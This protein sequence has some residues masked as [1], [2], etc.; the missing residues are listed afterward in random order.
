MMMFGVPTTWSGREAGGCSVT[1]LT[2]ADTPQF[3][4]VAVLSNTVGEVFTILSSV[5]GDVWDS[6]GRE[7]GSGS[8]TV[9]SC[10]RGQQFLAVKSI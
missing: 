7:A 1:V 6:H 9:L 4:A 3:L 10:A 2:G 5:V 8:V